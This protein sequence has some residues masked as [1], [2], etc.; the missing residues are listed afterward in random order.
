MTKT[1]TDDMRG[2]NL[3]PREVHENFLKRLLVVEAD[4]QS[5]MA[6][7]R[8]GLKSFADDKEEILKEA[9]AAG[10][11]VKVLKHLFKV[12]NFLDKNVTNAAQ[13]L[14]VDIADEVVAV[15]EQTEMFSYAKIGVHPTSEVATAAKKGLEDGTDEVQKQKLEDAKAFDEDPALKKSST[16]KGPSANDATEEE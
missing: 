2:H 1:N 12:E 8:A 13:R 6:K 16:P 15:M 5:Q 10:V 14:D 11:S 7:N 3:P 4:K 9:K